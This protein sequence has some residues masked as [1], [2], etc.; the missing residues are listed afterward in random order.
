MEHSRS[1]QAEWPF[2]ANM[3]PFKIGAGGRDASP[4][5]QYDNGRSHKELAIPQGCR[6]ERNAREHARGTAA[7]T[8]LASRTT[9]MSGGI[10]G[11]HASLSC[12]GNGAFGRML[13]V[14]S[15]DIRERLSHAGNH[16]EALPS[17]VGTWFRACKVIGRSQ[18]WTGRVLSL[19]CG[20]ASVFLPPINPCE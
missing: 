4:A 16:R 13:R 14:L 10:G 20:C 1:H 12:C 11:A 5:A 7:T 17:L 15:R 8:S 3:S 2:S 9:P 18:F 6:P 19:V